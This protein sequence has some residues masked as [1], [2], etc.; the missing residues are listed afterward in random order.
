MSLCGLRPRPPCASS[1]D[2]G[3]Y[4]FAAESVRDSRLRVRLANGVGLLRSSPGGKLGSGF[5]VGV[6][7]IDVEVIDLRF[8][9]SASREQRE[10]DE[11]P[12][13]LVCELGME[14]A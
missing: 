6:A 1:V 3:M 5:S 14:L 12:S 11:L 13:S 10:L 9:G 4:L 8:A 2:P 7:R